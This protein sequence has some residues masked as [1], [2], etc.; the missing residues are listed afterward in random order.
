MFG[1]KKVTT[2]KGK[3][4][5]LLNPSQK[6]EKYAC[7]LRE[8]HAMTNDGRFKADEDGPFPLTDTQKAYRSGYLDA[9]KDSARAYNYN[10]RKGR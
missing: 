7:E 8:R 2:K 10:K 5:T 1:G 6:A 3:T 4:I 9:R